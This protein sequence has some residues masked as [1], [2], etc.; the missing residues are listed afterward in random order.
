MARRR[1][2]ILDRRFSYGNVGTWTRSSSK[3]EL[4]LLKREPPTPHPQT[5][6]PSYNNRDLFS[7]CA[8]SMQLE[9]SSSKLCHFHSGL[10][11]VHFNIIPLSHDYFSYLTEISCFHILRTTTD[12]PLRPDNNDEAKRKVELFSM[13]AVSWHRPYCIR[14][15]GARC[16]VMQQWWNEHEEKIRRVWLMGKIPHAISPGRK[17]YRRRETPSL[18]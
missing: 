14:F 8:A 15:Y 1:V 18:T 12:L 16:V 11:K 9:Y 10:Y 4:M 6:Q 5:L 2:S 17:A 3:A 13:S 7:K